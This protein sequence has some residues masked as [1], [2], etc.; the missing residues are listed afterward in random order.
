[1]FWMPLS[2][3]LVTQ[4]VAVKYGAASKP[5][6]EIGTGRSFKPP[7]GFFRVVALDDDLLARRACRPRTGAIGLAIG[8][9]PRPG[10]SPRPACPC[11]WRRCAG[12]ADSAPTTTGMSYFLPLPSTTLVNRNAR[13]SSSGMPPTNCQRTSGCSSVSL[14]I[15]RS[16]RVTSP[17]ASSAA[18]CCWKSSAGPLVLAEPLRSC[19]ADRACGYFLLFCHASMIG[20]AW[21]KQST[22]HGMPQ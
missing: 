18:R 9:E 13:R 4:S 21:R 12:L 5:G 22:P 20:L 16:M 15:G 2:G 14:S 11:R 10:R 19:R 3:S 6:V 1:M 7:S 17:A 8:V